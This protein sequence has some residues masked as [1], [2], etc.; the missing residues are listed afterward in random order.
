MLIELST[1]LSRRDRSYS[2][3]IV[4]AC[5]F[6]FFFLLFHLVTRNSFII[7]RYC[8]KNYLLHS[9]R[10]IKMQ[11]SMCV[12]FRR[13][14]AW[15]HRW[16][17]LNIE[18]HFFSLDL[19]RQKCKTSIKNHQFFVLMLDKCNYELQ[20]NVSILAK[21]LCVFS[22]FFPIDI[23]LIFLHLGFIYWHFNGI[24]SKHW[25][26]VC[27]FALI[28]ICV[29]FTSKRRIQLYITYKRMNHCITLKNSFG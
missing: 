4:S 17:T 14:S 20:L 21:H 9:K 11:C 24:H 5:F 1:I 26:L 16:D 23:R 2:N 8:H 25:L 12:H 15:Y 3:S 22:S 6:F 27:Q 7:L 13:I 19:T 10:F 29:H 18:Q 28:S